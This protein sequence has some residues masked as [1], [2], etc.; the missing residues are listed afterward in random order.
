MYSSKQMVQEVSY[1]A[2]FDFLNSLYSL[3][4]MSASGKLAPLCTLGLPK[5]L[6][7]FYRKNGFNRSSNSCALSSSGFLL[8]R[9][10]CYLYRFKIS[11]S[12]C[13][14]AWVL[15]CQKNSVKVFPGAKVILCQLSS[16]SKLFLGLILSRVPNDIISISATIRVTRATIYTK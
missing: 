5:S 16:F 15:R 6:S 10:I 11:S 9:M 4:S 3:R 8:L 14:V 2:T 12:S 7:A 13:S 1:E